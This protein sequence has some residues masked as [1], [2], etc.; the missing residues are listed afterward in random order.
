MGFFEKIK[1]G[2]SKTRDQ[3]RTRIEWAVKGK[4]IDEGDFEAIEEAL[5]LSD[6]GFETT[7]FLVDALKEKW[8]RGL[9]RNMEDIEPAMKQKVGELLRPVEKPISVDSQKPF[10][11]LTLGVN[12]VGKTT[13]IA[14]L[15]AIYQNCGKKVLLG[16]C[17]T[18]RAAAV[19]QLEVWAERL[20]VDVVKH[21]EGSDPAAVAFD[22]TKA[23]K[24][25][26]ADIVILDTAGRLHTKANLMEEMKKIKRVISKEVNG[27]PHEVLLVVDATTG[28]NTLAQVKTFNEVLEVTGIVVT[29]LDGTAKGGFIL[30]IAHLMKMPI[31]Y[32]GVGEKID[33]LIPFSAEDFAEGLFSA[34]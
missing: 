28:Q 23:A 22:A 13:T 18:F 14:K 4:Q 1:N 10:V 20:G 7:E 12:G 33:D 29:K 17:D 3:I 19:E 8:K 11:I 9:I 31:R 5:I 34:K 15:A 27:A 2:L 30:P 16:A 24:A 26:A 6:A 32:I 21:A 25:R